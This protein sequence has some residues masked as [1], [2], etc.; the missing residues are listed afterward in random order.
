[1]A[2]SGE[3]SYNASRAF[4]N[5]KVGVNNYS[6]IGY[7]ADGN[8]T[9]VAKFQIIFNPTGLTDADKTA[10]PEKTESAQTD[11]VPTVG[12]TTFGAPIV[13]QPA[14]GATI[15][16]APIT[17]LGTVPAGTK[18]VLVNEYPLSKFTAG[19][20][21]WNYRADP[22][23]SNLKE[24]ENEYEIVAV[25]ETGERSSI[26]IKITYKPAAPAAE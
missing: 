2:G 23:F 8:K 3:W 24:G 14:D 15:T 22:K 25:S 18:Q 10:T 1:V 9:P 12:S 13:S 26:T 7:D 21:S 6:V 19:S 16:E 11:G 5:L 4:G 20:T 17:F